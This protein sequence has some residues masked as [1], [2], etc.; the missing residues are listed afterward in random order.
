MLGLQPLMRLPTYSPMYS[1]MYAP[2]ENLRLSQ[3]AQ[4]LEVFALLL[5]DDS[6]FLTME[7][8]D[9]LLLE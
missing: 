1:P 7:T 9:L 6:G 2:E 5:E 4:A 8:G 3:H